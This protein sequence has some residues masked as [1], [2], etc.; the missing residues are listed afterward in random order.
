MVNAAGN[1]LQVLWTG[2]AG[3]ARDV[4]VRERAVDVQARLLSKGSGTEDPDNWD[5]LHR[6][7]PEV[8]VAHVQV[9]GGWGSVGVDGHDA[10]AEVAGR[11]G[12]GRRERG[13]GATVSRAHGVCLRVVSSPPPP[14][15][16]VTRYVLDY[17][18]TR[19]QADACSLPF[20]EA[21][22]GLIISLATRAKFKKNALF[23]KVSTCILLYT[24]T[25]CAQA[26]T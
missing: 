24:Q 13:G 22:K 16:K 15:S 9:L 8:R 10:T 6:T 26:N 17:T 3:H 23:T 25:T 14:N 1:Q 7:R 19:L 20:Y 4:E 2:V 18:S 21:V 11:E 5:L 12:G